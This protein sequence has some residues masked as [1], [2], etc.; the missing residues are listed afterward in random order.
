MLDV[1]DLVV[2]EFTDIL[3]GRLFDDPTGGQRQMRM[4][5]M[6][7][8]SKRSSVDLGRDYP[9]LLLYVRGGDDKAYASTFMV[10]LVAGFHINPDRDGD[11]DVDGDDDLLTPAMDTMAYIVG[12]FR[13][14]HGGTYTPYSLEGIRWQIGDKDGAHPGPDNF[15]VA[16]ELSFQQQAIF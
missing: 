7:L 10:D 1:L 4:L 9:F 13:L 16:A 3:N 12:C 8:Q 15:M 14:L 6:G 5:K 11:G 2:A